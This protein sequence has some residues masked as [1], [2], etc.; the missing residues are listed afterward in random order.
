MFSSWINDKVPNHN[1]EI[2]VGDCLSEVVTL[3]VYDEINNE[4]SCMSTKDL[5]ID[6]N[7]T[8]WMHKPEITEDL[9]IYDNAN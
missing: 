8:H 5:P 6:F 1:D 7:V 9:F 2:I 4:F 3:A